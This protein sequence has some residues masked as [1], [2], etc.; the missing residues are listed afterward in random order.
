M[1]Y[2]T[3]YNDLKHEV[4]YISSLVPGALS[5]IRAD[6]LPPPKKIRSFDSVM[7]LEVSSEESSDSS[8]LKETSLRDD[9][10][11]GVAMSLTHSLISTL[12]FRRRSMSVMHMQMLLKDDADKGGS[13]E[14][15]SE[16]DINPEIK[17]EID[18]CIAY[19]DDL[20]AEGIDDRGVVETVAQEEVKTSMRGM[21]KVRVDRVTHPI[22][23]DD[24]N[25]PAQEDGSIEGTYE[26]LGDLGYMIVVTGQQSAVLSERISALERDKTRLRGTLDVEDVNKGGNRNGGVNGNGNDNGNRG[27]NDNGNGKGN[28]GEIGYGNHNMNQK[29]LKGYARN[30]KNKRRFDDKPRDKRGQQPAFKRQ[31]V[32]VQNVAR[33]YTAKNNKKRVMLDL[34][35]T[36]TNACCTMKGRVL[37]FGSS[38]FSALLDVA[39]STLDTSYAV[40]LADRRISETNVVLRGC[41]LGLLGRPLEI[42]LMLKVVRILYGDEVLIIRGD[43]CDYESKSKLNIVSCTNPQKYIQK[44]GQVYLAQ[45]TSKKTE[46]N[47]EEKRLEDVPIVWEFLEV[48]REDLHGLPPTRQVEFQIDLAHTSAPVA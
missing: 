45:V 14:P 15:Y 44:A 6:L 1:N 2:V 29:K 12:R 22:V 37:I 47:L 28:R 19:A 20:K 24:I 18:E 32:R 48:F 7:D 5:S 13:D 10:N 35:L 26:K 41:T 46:E 33:A 27:G 43:D 42:D 21:V 9:I 17:A 31:N 25:E 3:L 39:P 4:L 34:S 8:I 30:A 36:A 11:V 38:T 16:P 23:S 40:E